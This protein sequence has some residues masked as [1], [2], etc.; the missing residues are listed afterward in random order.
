MDGPLPRKRRLPLEWEG[1]VEVVEF[2][3]EIAAFADVLEA[4]H[5]QHI[6]MEIVDKGLKCLCTYLGPRFITFLVWRV[7]IVSHDSA[8]IPGV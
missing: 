6:S 2:V 5:D 3:R 7:C 8:V 1:T 4:V